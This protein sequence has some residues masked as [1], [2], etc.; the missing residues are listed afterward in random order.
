M[1]GWQ[2]HVMG[3]DDLVP[4][5]T[6]LEAINLAH[7]INGQI[8]HAANFQPDTESYRWAVPVPPNNTATLERQR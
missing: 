2:V 1:S 4:V 5:R 8:H 3:P 7:R 6:Q